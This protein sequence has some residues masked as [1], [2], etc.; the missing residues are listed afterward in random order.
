M[1]GGPVLRPGRRR[2]RHVELRQPDAAEHVAVRVARV[3]VDQRG[4]RRPVTARGPAVQ[5]VVRR[6]L[7]HVEGHARE[8]RRRAVRGAAR[9]VVLGRCADIADPQRPVLDDQLPV[10]VRRPRHLPGTHPARVGLARRRPEE[11]ERVGLRLQLPDGRADVGAHGRVAEDA[12][13]HEAVVDAG[14]WVDRVV[15]GAQPARRLR[16]AGR[17]HA[18]SAQR[19]E[20]VRAARAP[21]RLAG[22]R[23]DVVGQRVVGDRPAVGQVERAVATGVPR[24]QPGRR[25]HAGALRRHAHPGVARAHEVLVRLQPVD[26]LV[27]L[28]RDVEPLDD[29]R[30][31]EVALSGRPA[32]D[33]PRPERVP[34]A[35]DGRR[36]G[37]VRGVAR[38]L[39]RDEELT[40]HVAVEGEVVVGREE[41]VVVRRIARMGGRGNRALD[42][43]RGLCG[44][45]EHGDGE[46][47]DDDGEGR[48]GHFL[49]PCIERTASP[50]A[51]RSPHP[52]QLIRPALVNIRA[53]IGKVSCRPGGD[54][55]GIS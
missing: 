25:V 21:Q 40:L 43:R 39:A 30:A 45:R 28:V 31:V 17:Q 3:E 8:R 34:G 15:V 44:R 54:S 33:H 51:A 18:A 20:R 46:Q 29:H 26:F 12:V 55:S 49:L 35:R 50:H 32:H 13:Q 1:P 4:R 10:A 42:L 27:V 52:C 16:M 48:P 38:R 19:P 9:R 2:G 7:D 36:V 6:G 37:A 41:R 11:P 47:H 24:P 5:P 22:L 14:E 53:R 23:E